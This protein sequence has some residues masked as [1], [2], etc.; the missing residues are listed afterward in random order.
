MVVTFEANFWARK[1]IEETGITWPLLIDETREI[2]RAYNMLKAGFW[3]IWGPRSWLAY[4][5]ELLRGRLPKPAHD[6]INQRGGDAL[7]SPDNIVKLHHVGAG[8]ADRPGIDTIL[9]AIS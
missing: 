1:Y 4:L 7:I 8:P 5:K 6:D 2:Y 3:D 9:N